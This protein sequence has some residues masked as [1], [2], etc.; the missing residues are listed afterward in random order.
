MANLAAFLTRA[1]PN[2]VGTMEGVVEYGLKICGHPAV[3][4]I[5]F[6]LT[7]NIYH[8]SHRLIFYISFLATRRFRKDMA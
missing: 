7:Y 2:N 5:G 3:R 6:Q 8:F 1:V 4:N